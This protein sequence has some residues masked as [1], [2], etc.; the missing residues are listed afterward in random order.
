MR[1]KQSLDT[2]NGHVAQTFRKPA[3]KMYI[4][5]SK[6]SNPAFEYWAD[7]LLPGKDC[8]EGSISGIV[9][10]LKNS[11]LDIVLF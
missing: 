4:N 6:G 1:N 8:R 3:R 9:N 11:I 2:V 7:K 5:A 10:F